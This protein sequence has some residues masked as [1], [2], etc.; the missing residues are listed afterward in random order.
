[1]HSSY[2][3]VP[4]VEL[5][6]WSVFEV[7]LYGVDA[8][9]TRHIVGYAQELGLAQVSSTIVMFDHESSCGASANHRVFQ[10]VG[11]S[12]GHPEA[13]RLWERWKALNDVHHERD[14][15]AHFYQAQRARQATV[16]AIDA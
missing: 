8:P 4:I 12:G 9:W 2:Q 1:M 7:P 15:T 5:T 6:H 3:Y 14:I 11:G 13:K 16:T 10:I